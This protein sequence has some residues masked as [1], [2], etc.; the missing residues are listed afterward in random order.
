M[1]ES[2]F[3]RAH[4]AEALAARLPPLLLAA[5][6]LAATVQHGMHGRRRAGPGSA[7]WQFRRYQA[8][9]AAATIDWRRSARSD[10]LFARE[11]EWTAAQAV[12]LWRDGSSSMEF[13]R[14]SKKERAGLLLLALASLLARAGERVGLLGAEAP[15]AT[16]R[17]ATARLAW[18]LEH[19]VPEGTP[20]FRPLPRHARLV[21]LGDFL[22][23]AEV[24]AD[25]LGAY[26]R[27]GLRGHLLQVLDPAEETLPYAGRVLFEG[28]EGEGSLL[29]GRAEAL[30][31]DYRE[32][33]ARHR[34]ALASL[35]AGWGWSLAVH[36]T[37]QPPETAL[38]A[39]HGVLSG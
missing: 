9:D 20:P 18:E 7:F 36:R 34:A 27:L 21:W 30:R 39:L 32:A 10:Q 8:G 35:A 37:D 29:A 14:P 15:P 25:R 28:P 33:L 2:A 12:W 26:A 16:G 5:E 31:P 11:R 17:G 22:E 19:A 1:S 6:R 24:L 13:G 4:E 3:R 38:L 23:P